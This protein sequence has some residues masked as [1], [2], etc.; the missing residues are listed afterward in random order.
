[1]KTL[2]ELGTLHDTDK[3]PHAYLPHYAKRFARLRNYSPVIGSPGLLE[4]GV[5]DGASLR[6]WRDYFP[7]G[8]IYGIDVL[9]ESTISEERI[10]CFCGKQQHL[11]FLTGVISWIG[12]LDIVI[13]DG[14]HVGKHHV[15]SFEILWPH[16][17]PGGWYCIEDAQSIFN[18]CWTQPSHRTM[19]DVLQEQW[20]DILR[21]KSD[22]AEVAIIGCDTRQPRR[23][24]N[25]GLIFLQKAYDDPQVNEPLTDEEE[26]FYFSSREE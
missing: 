26:S 15:A 16:V 13:D 20:S 25:N 1:M 19:F 18:T 4:I 17:N 2:L 12:N 11:E 23:G 22:I 3:V 5:M 8:M 7:N 21:S 24:R 6:M 10:K 14:S 9:P